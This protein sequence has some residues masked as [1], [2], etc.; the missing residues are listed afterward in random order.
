M[1]RLFVAIPLPQNVIEHLLLM[2]RG[3][4]GARWTTREQFHLTLRFIGN[5]DER[6]A[7]AVDDALAGIS[8]PGFTLALSGIGTFGGK[9]PRQLWVG[10]RDGEALCHL[11]RKTET[12][13]QRIGLEPEGRKFTPHV[14]L[15]K[16]KAAPGGRIL[17]FIADHSLYASAPFDVKE[18]ILYSSVLT[19]NGSI[20]QPERHYPLR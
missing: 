14:T 9:N 6:M 17:D 10:V 8:A 5:V 18:F 7:A 1:I 16:L 15:A 2:Q 19:P 11:Q 13:M 4:P 3:V 12:A 20:Y